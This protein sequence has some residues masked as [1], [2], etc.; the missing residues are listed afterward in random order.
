VEEH[1][2]DW[3]SGTYNGKTGVFPANY[4]EKITEKDQ[5]A[6][7]EKQS[8]SA[9]YRPFRTAHHGT[10]LPPPPGGGAVNSVGLQQDP[11]QEKKGKYGKFGN[12]V[13]C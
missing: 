2:A 12:T 8:A 11:D 3:W 7:N 10:D 9:V 6:S 5:F 4:V 1:N 13:S